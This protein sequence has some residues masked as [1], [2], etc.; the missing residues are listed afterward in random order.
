MAPNTDANNTTKD[1]STTDDSKSTFTMKKT[2][3][4]VD[5]TQEVEEQTQKGRSLLLQSGK[6]KLRDALEGLMVWEKKSRL[7]C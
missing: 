1:E 4:E 2:K 5:Y 7:V 6:S 3:K